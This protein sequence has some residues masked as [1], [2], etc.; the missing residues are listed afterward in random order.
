[1]LDDPK[2]S[3]FPGFYQL[4]VHLKAGKNTAVRNYYLTE[5][6]DRLISGTV[7]DL[8]KSPFT[9]NLQQLKQ[10]GAPATGPENAPIQIYVFS[11]FECPYC[12]EEAKV[13]RQGI[14]KT[15]AKDVRLIFKDFPLDPS[16]PGRGR[17]HRP[18]T[19]S[20][21]RMRM[22]SGRFTTGSTSTRRRSSRTT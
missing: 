17:R 4:T 5:D 21:T 3:A 1:M 18:G 14:E 8:K 10:E 2:P 20:R 7:F 9:T 16:I 15:H 19:A 13:L 12:R 6:G 11:D 22:R